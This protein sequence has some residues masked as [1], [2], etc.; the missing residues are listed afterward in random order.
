M[1]LLVALGSYRPGRRYRYECFGRRALTWRGSLVHDLHVDR[2]RTRN[3]WTV[4]AVC[5][6]PLPARERVEGTE[7]PAEVPA[8]GRGDLVRAHVDAVFEPAESF[9]QPASG[10]FE[11]CGLVLVTDVVDRRVERREF[12]L[13]KSIAFGDGVGE[14]VQS[15]CVLPVPSATLPSRCAWLRGTQVGV[16]S[17]LLGVLRRP[18]GVADGRVLPASFGPA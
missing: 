12:G 13:E 9:G 1:L 6:P 17:G 7:L 2:Y 4:N 14:G 3:V 15:V 16:A 5:L 11:L 10:G 18:D 8:S